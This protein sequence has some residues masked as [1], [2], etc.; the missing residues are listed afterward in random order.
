MP[1][2]PAENNPAYADVV[3][4]PDFRRYLNVNY[5]DRADNPQAPISADD[6]KT[7]TV[8]AANNSGAYEL[9]PVPAYTA[10][11]ANYRIDVPNADGETTLF[12]GPRCTEPAV[13]PSLEGLQYA[14]NLEILM[15]ARV[16]DLPD[17]ISFPKLHTVDIHLQSEDSLPGLNGENFPAL[18]NLAVDSHVNTQLPADFATLSTLTNLEMSINGM[19]TL[20]QQVTELPA[21]ETLAVQTL[22]LTSLPESIGNLTTLRELNLPYSGLTTLPAG[23]G[24]LSN[25]EVL[26]VNGNPMAGG[27]LTTLPESIGNLTNLREL[28][29]HTQP[30]SELPESIGNLV[31]L[32]DLNLKGTRIFAL[33]ESILDLPS[34]QNLDVSYTGIRQGDATVEELRANGVQ[35]EHAGY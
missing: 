24:N 13:T 6:M 12:C 26:H 35:V 3:P 4:N 17:P 14:T 23:I 19:Q 11:E 25:L 10:E 16:A 27:Y 29:L 5:F 31:S 22:S 20:P 9:D 2:E 7:L 34:L 15:I 18:T 30:L 1:E 33:P 8:L 21:L 28:N 32:Q